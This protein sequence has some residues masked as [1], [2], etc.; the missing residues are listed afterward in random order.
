MSEFS[1]KWFE[2]CNKIINS[3]PYT[4]PDDWKYVWTYEVEE[5]YRKIMNVL[6]RVEYGGN[7]INFRKHIVEIKKYKKICSGYNSYRNSIYSDIANFQSW[8]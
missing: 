5:S 6:H 1:L 3:I 2:H 8:G 4:P 7:S